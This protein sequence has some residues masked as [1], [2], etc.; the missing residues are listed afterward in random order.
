MERKRG[1]R[2]WPR[3]SALPREHARTLDARETHELES[4]FHA[5]SFGRHTETVEATSLPRGC[6]LR[7][8]PST[9]QTASTVV[10]WLS[11]FLVASYRRMTPGLRSRRPRFGTA[12]GCLAVSPSTRQGRSCSTS[13]A[14]GRGAGSS[15]FHRRQVLS[16]QVGVLGKDAILQAGAHNVAIPQLHL[17]T[18]AGLPAR[19]PGGAIG[20]STSVPFPV[21]GPWRRN[22]GSRRLPDGLRRH[23]EAVSPVAPSDAPL[24]RRRPE[25][26]SRS[27]R[28]CSWATHQPLAH[29]RDMERCH[30]PRGADS[31][32]GF[33]LAVFAHA[34]DVAFTA[35]GHAETPPSP[36]K[37]QGRGQ[38]VV[39]QRSHS[40][41]RT[42]FSGHGAP[43]PRGSKDQEC[44]GHA[45]ISPCRAARSC[46]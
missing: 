14:T 6:H 20:N 44:L 22:I 3:W 27:P 21:G 41:E 35:E 34:P 40:G 45:V 25:Y 15:A 39:G 43:W 7:P 12:A 18:P 4:R 2:S 36:A 26:C 42:G 17:G 23:P 11:W 1:S 38:P 16:G 10:C 37:A 29:Q 30:L 24:K 8:G 28:N 32:A 13:S 31:V 5:Q 19:G 46:V 33:S 9:Q